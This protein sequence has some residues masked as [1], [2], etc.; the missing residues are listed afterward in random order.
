M[1][2][3]TTHQTNDEAGTL[4]LAQ[5]L[6]RV[7]ECTDIVMLNGPLGAGKSVMARGIIQT[8]SHTPN[9]DIPSPTFTLV[10]QYDTSK[11]RLWHYDLYRLE[12]AEEVYETGWEDIAGQDIALIEWAEN[13]NHLMPHKYINITIEP[14]GSSVRNITIEK[15]P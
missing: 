9:E 7:L 12:N 3:F 11:G 1:D 4:L 13:L 10:Q 8:L 5:H 6:A 15:V 14:T 2:V